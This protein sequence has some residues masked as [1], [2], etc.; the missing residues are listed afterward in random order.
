MVEP[1]LKLT[2]GK[3]QELFHLKFP[4][5]WDE[6]NQRQLLYIAKYWEAW[7]EIS[8]MHGERLVK[9][10]AL[11]V[12]ELCGITGRRERRRLCNALSHVTEDSGFNILDYTNFVF[13]KLTLTRN[14][15]PKIKVGLFKWYFGPGDRL[16]D[17]D[18]EEFSMAFSAY[19]QYISTRNE[20]HLNNL[21]AILYRPASQEYHITGDIRVPYNFKKITEYVKKIRKIPEEYKQAVLLFFM[22]CLDYFSQNKRYGKVFRRAKNESESSGGSFFDTV[23]DMSG[24]KFGPYETTRR[25]NVHIFLKDLNNHIERQKRK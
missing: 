25:T 21:V 4:E 1:I 6:L 18:I 11:L 12:L 8:Q 15:L 13:E 20:I 19:S 23:V 5:K 9:A 14:L 16:N 2:I 10:R 22:G 3:H 24:G 17:I 7:Q